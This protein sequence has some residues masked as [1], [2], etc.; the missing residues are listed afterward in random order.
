LLLC[1]HPEHCFQFRSIQQYAWRE[2]SLNWFAK[3]TRPADKKNQQL[4]AEMGFLSAFLH[5]FLHFCMGKHLVVDSRIFSYWSLIILTVTV[6][7]LFEG[8]VQIKID[9]AQCDDFLPVDV[10]CVVGVRGYLS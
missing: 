5:Y 7:N 10:I 3:G 2:K 1:C 9:G 4:L 6:M 8:M